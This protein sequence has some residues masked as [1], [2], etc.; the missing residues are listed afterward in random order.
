MWISHVIATRRIY[1][2]IDSMNVLV[3]S[4]VANSCDKIHDLHKLR[5]DIDAKAQLTLE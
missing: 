4:C 1:S 3:S 5:E 2:Y